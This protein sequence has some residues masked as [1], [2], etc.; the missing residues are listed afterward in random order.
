MY[1]KLGAAKTT[2]TGAFSPSQQ[3]FRSLASVDQYSGFSTML[4]SLFRH[5]LQKPFARNC[6]TLGPRAIQAPH[7]PAAK[8]G[9]KIFGARF[10]SDAQRRAPQQRQQQQWQQ[11]QPPPP[12]PPPEMPPDMDESSDSTLKRLVVWPFIGINVVVFLWWQSA[13]AEAR[14]NGRDLAR[15]PQQ[16]AVGARNTIDINDPATG[17]LKHMMSNYTLSLRNMREGRW[18]TLLTCA[19]SHATLDHLVFNMISFNAFAGF[20]I[21]SGVPLPTLLALGVGSGL[22]SDMAC[23]YDWNRKRKETP[24]LGASGVISGLGTAMACMR[25]MASFGIILIPVGIPLSLLMVGYI[26]YDS[27]RLNSEESNVGHSAHLGGSAFGVVF[28]ML[29]LRKYGGVWNM[30][31]R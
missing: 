10:R 13:E 4:Q 11:R 18:H 29:F 6:S 31:R 25:P 2:A 3:E 30:L 19:I 15:T 5:G 28:Y 24:G 1:F 27:Y 16:R 17:Q 20:A 26:A 7:H 23:L 22:A 21:M 12:P 9:C 8:L 14:R